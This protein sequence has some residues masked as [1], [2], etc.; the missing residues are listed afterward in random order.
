MS[1]VG[2]YTFRGSSGEDEHDNVIVIRSGKFSLLKGFQ[3]ADSYFPK[4]Y[5]LK[6]YLSQDEY[7]KGI[8]LVNQRQR[9]DARICCCYLFYQMRCWL[10]LTWCHKRRQK[11][12]MENVALQS[13]KTQGLGVEFVP[14]QPRLCKTPE[15]VTVPSTPAEIRIT[16]LN[17]PPQSSTSDSAKNPVGK[18]SEVSDMNPIGDFAE[19]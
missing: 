4:P 17:P 11:D 15:H 7:S 8:D 6:P 9:D 12:H 3:F 18:P 13:W 16:L 19:V 10:P 1:I 5:L 2:G 14:G